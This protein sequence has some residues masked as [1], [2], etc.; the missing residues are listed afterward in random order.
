MTQVFDMMVLN[1]A[2]VAQESSP[3]DKSITTF[4]AHE[5]LLFLGTDFAIV[6]KT[7]ERF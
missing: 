5:E 1:V 6:Y 4:A 7:Q 3:R 2:G